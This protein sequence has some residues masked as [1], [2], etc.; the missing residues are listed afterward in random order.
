MPL[1]KDMR[2]LIVDDHAPMR[3]LVASILRRFGFTNLH[4]A[5]NGAAAWDRLNKYDIDF[6][7]LDWDM[8][9]MSGIELLARIRRDEIMED[10]P[11][12]MVT[13]EAQQENVIRAIQLKV[14]NYIVKPYTPDKLFEKIR[15]I[16]E[17]D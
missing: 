3:K 5:E 12:L 11:V 16:F 4:Y 15:E 6:V 13:A 2:I 17:R 14:T 8:P 1:D 7:M 9:V 10:L